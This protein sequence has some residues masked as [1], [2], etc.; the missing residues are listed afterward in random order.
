M[1]IH[2]EIVSVIGTAPS[3]LPLEGCRGDAR[4]PVK[5]HLHRGIGTAI[6]D[7]APDIAKNLTLTI[8]LPKIGGI[9]DFSEN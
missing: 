4:G 2:G 7:R 5:T 9:T 8:Y 3:F 6:T 1:I